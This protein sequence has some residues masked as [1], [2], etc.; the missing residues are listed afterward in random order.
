MEMAVNQ[1][2]R[3]GRK[4]ALTCLRF[5]DIIGPKT[6]HPLSQYLRLPVVPTI[7]GFDPRLQFC[8]EE[9]AVGA[10]KRATLLDIPG[11][12]NVA[13]DGV[14]YL[15]RVLRLGGRFGVP[16]APPFVPM[17]FSLLRIFGLADIQPYHL[18]TLRYGRAVDNRRL[19][20][21]FGFTPR[22]STVDAVFD[23]YNKA[24][25]SSSMWDEAEPSQEEKVAAA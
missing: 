25:L 5:A 9:D 22:Y 2:G 3:S 18:L 7:M 1:L 14:I 19:K 4:I 17:I 21:R 6:G 11:L 15:S 12:Y 23:L 24:T 20:T 13:G 10:L 8:H 16:I